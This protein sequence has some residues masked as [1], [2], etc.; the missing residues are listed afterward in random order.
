LPSQDSPDI[1]VKYWD[2]DTWTNLINETISFRISRKGL[3]ALPTLEVVL[4]N[5]KGKFF[6]PYNFSYNEDYLNKGLAYSEASCIEIWCDIG[7]G[8]KNMF[9]G[10][11]ERVECNPSIFHKDEITVLAYHEHPQLLKD[12]VTKD[13]REL[14]KT[15]SEALEEL[16]TDPDSGEGIDFVIE[17]DGGIITTT[18]CKEDFK[19]EKLFDAIQRLMETIAYDGYW[20]YKYTSPFRKLNVY[21]VG[22]RTIFKSYDKPHLLI[23]PEISLEEIFSKIYVFGGIDKGLPKDG[24]SAFTENHPSGTWSSYDPSPTNFEEYD[25]DTVKIGQYSV[26]V[27]HATVPGTRV[28]LTC[29]FINALGKRLDMSKRFLKLRVWRRMDIGLSSAHFWLEDKDGNIIEHTFTPYYVGQWIEQEVGDL[30]KPIDE[31]EL[32]TQEVGT[33]FDWSKIEKFHCVASEGYAGYI[34]LDGLMFKGYLSIDPYEHPDLNPPA[35]VEEG[36]GWLGY[37][38]LYH[39]RKEEIETFEEAQ[40]IAKLLAQILCKPLWRMK[41]KVKVEPEIYPSYLV[42][43]NLPDY[44]IENEVFRVIEV[45]H[46]FEKTNFRTELTLVKR[47]DFH[48]FEK[49]SLEVLPG[50]LKRLARA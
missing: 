20:G 6:H 24:D 47:Y 35:Q 23:K 26:E 44:G 2:G 38:S 36:K 3:Q 17:H 27:Y 29:N 49:L 8:F 10:Y 14:G 15:I 46:I 43:V 22:T 12:S 9:R 32:W 18:K 45:E 41:I 7:T 48:Q 40:E 4:D 11:I 42:K 50:I 25:T 19:G 37:P 13:F 28:G 16:L 34:D 33:T 30:G 21:P 1:S 5:W 39:F 31:T